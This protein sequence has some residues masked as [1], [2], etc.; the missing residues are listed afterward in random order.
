MEQRRVNWGVDMDIRAFFDRLLRQWPVRF[1]EHRIGDRPLLRLITEWL[2]AGVME[3]GHWSD[4]GKG[5]P[6]G[7]IATPL[8]S[9]RSGKSGYGNLMTMGA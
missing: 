4:T 9:E 7:A 3:D 1:L 5:T 8:L 2:N 6:R